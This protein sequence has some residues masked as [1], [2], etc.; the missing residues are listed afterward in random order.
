M[1]TAWKDNALVLFMSTIHKASFKETVVM[2]N[3]K[4][5]S[6]T[7]SAA[8]TAQAPFESQPRKVLP[9]LKL[10]DDYNYY[11]GYVDQADQLCESEPSKCLVCRGR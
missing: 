2:Q 1:Q 6:K 4:C 9:I 10:V 5:P 11:I 7:L 8:K 3:C